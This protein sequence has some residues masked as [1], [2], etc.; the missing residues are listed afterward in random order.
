MASTIASTGL[1]DD[2]VDLD[3]RDEV[4]LVLRSAVGLGVAALTPEAADLADG[5]AGDTGR[6]ECVLDVVELERLDDCGDELHLCS[7][8]CVESTGAIRSDTVSSAYTN[9]G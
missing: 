7:F 6:L 5:H 4:D 3:L 1:V 9:S 8:V 2:D